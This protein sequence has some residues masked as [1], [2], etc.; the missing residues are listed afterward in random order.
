MFVA[1]GLEQLKYLAQTVSL[2]VLLTVV[3]APP[4]YLKPKIPQHTELKYL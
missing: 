1:D 4:Q 2:S 3:R